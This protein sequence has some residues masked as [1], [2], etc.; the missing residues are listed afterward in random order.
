MLAAGDEDGINSTS[1]SITET[2]DMIRMTRGPLRIS[3]DLLLLFKRLPPF[4]IHQ[5][6]SSPSAVNRYQ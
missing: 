4:P 6:R 1:E 5:K 2:I 3:S